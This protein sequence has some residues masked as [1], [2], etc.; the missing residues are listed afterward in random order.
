[1]ATIQQ[2]FECRCRFVRTTDLLPEAGAPAIGQMM[3][4]GAQ[5]MRSA[6]TPPAR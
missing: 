5:A 6:L 2:E 4:A 3:E 1:M